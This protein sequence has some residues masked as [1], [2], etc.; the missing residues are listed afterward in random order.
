MLRTYKYE[1]CKYS[2]YGLLSQ[3]LESYYDALEKN[4]KDDTEHNL[5]HLETMVERLFFSIKHRCVE[6]KLNEIEAEEMLCYLRGLL[7]D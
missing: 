1:P 6:G 7:D 5:V 2:S 3:D 4:K